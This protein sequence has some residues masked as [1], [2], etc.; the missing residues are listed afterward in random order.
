MP[1]RACDSGTLIAVR[2]QPSSRPTARGQ[3]PVL[4][5]ATFPF[6]RVPAMGR[7]LSNSDSTTR[8]G[9]SWAVQRH[10]ASACFRPPLNTHGQC[11]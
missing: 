9:L 11:Q 3:P 7:T 2:V 6:L 4:T 8:R 5:D 10:V 1:L